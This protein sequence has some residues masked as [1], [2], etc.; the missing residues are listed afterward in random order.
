MMDTDT[1]LRYKAAGLLK[2]RI[3]TQWRDYLIGTFALPAKP[4]IVHIPYS[5][6]LVYR[7]SHCG[8]WHRLRACAPPTPFYAA[9]FCGPCNVLI[10]MDCREGDDGE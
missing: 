6:M 5:P 2:E 9:G 8:L 3:E 10:L 7:C 1:E 4:E